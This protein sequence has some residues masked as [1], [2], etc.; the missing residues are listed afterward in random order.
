[1]KKSFKNIM[2]ITSILTVIWA[3]NN[4]IKKSSDISLS[5]DSVTKSDL[6]YNTKFGN[7]RY[8][9]SEE[10]SKKP[11]I[12][13]LHTLMMGGS[14][15]EY[16]K[17][18]KM[19]SDKFCVYRF[20]MLGYGY[21]DKPNIS[22]N[23]YLY[24]TLI[25]S[26]IKDVIKDEVVVLA[27][28]GSADFAFMAREMNDSLMKELFMINPN[29]VNDSSVYGS[30]NN[31]ITKSLVSL[32]IIGTFIS[33]IISSK[34]NIKQQLI[35]KGFYNEYGITD[36]IIN[37]IHK[38]AHFKCEDNRYALAHLYTN[39]LKV[40]LKSALLNSKKQTF[41]IL[42]ENC[43]QFESYNIKSKLF[44]NDNNYIKIIPM[45]KSLIALE[46]P[47]EVFNFIISNI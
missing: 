27:S 4:K 37:Q 25:N 11:K 38:N 36:D 26:F 46:K 17:L 41:I 40:D 12:L 34:K 1:M 3:I 29:G 8:K 20:D 14:L 39:F 10:D 19:L 24:S 42:G 16:D 23:S 18:T 47:K 9:V 28:G 6:F 30:F 45:T 44:I 33:N 43:T 7:I 15:Q 22:Y 32:P 31:K 35:E 13:L 21:S 5:E 2:R